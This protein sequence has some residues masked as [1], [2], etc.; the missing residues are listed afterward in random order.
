MKIAVLM[1]GPSREREVSL[2]SGKA[3]S[4]ALQAKGYQVIE[5]TDMDDLPGRLKADS[6]NAVFIAL[7]GRFGEDGTVQGILEEAGWVYTGS[8][9]KASYTAL[10]KDLAKAEFRRAGLMTPEWFSGCFNKCIELEKK[11]KGMPFPIVLKPIDEGSSIGLEILRSK[12][13]LPQAFERIL[14]FSSHILVE[15]FIEG[16]ELTVG[17]LGEQP[18]PI[19]EIKTDRS[20]YDY[21]AKYTPGHTQYEVPAQLPADIYSQ[22]QTIGLKAHQALKCRDLSRVDI[23]LDRNNTPWVLEVNTIPGFTQTSLLPKAARAAGI[24]FEDLCE[25]IIQM[26][27]KRLDRD[28]SAKTVRL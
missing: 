14:R 20:F 17:V 24:S 7:H 28:A 10:H 16:R 8:D 18:L 3:I 13:N 1:G 15:Q 6:I 5:I 11:L 26:A 25:R 22:I 21:E 9:S 19:V 2:R 27:I 4:L 23:L 12:D